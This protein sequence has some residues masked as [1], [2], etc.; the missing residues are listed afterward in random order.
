MLMFSVR[1]RAI[2]IDITLE[3]VSV[4]S[5]GE[6]RAHLGDFARAPAPPSA[7]LQRPGRWA[8]RQGVPAAPPSRRRNGERFQGRCERRRRARS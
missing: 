6:A 2:S 3:E 8:P 1:L 7:Q 5:G 4:A